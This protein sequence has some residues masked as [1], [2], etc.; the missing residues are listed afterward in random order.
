[1]IFVLSAIAELIREAGKCDFAF[2][3]K[4]LKNLFL[5]D[6]ELLEE[7]SFKDSILAILGV[8]Y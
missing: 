5:I 8:V 4:F 2:T 1:M 6:G 3:E 7:S